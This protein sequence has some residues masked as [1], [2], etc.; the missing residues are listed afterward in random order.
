MSKSDNS[1]AIRSGHKESA[2]LLVV[3]KYLSDFRP[4]DDMIQWWKDYKKNGCSNQTLVEKCDRLIIPLEKYRKDLGNKVRTYA[5]SADSAIEMQRMYGRESNE[6]KDAEILFNQKKR[7]IVSTIDGCGRH[8]QALVTRWFLE[9]DHFKVVDMEM[10]GQG[11]DF[12]ILIADEY[13][14]RYD[15]EVWFGH[16]KRHHAARESTMIFGGSKDNP[17][18]DYGSVPVRLKNVASDQ[19]EINM[20]SAPD[21][22][23]VMK[24]LGQ[25]RD[26][27]TGFLIACRPQAI[28]PEITAT[29]FPTVLP[30]SI[31]T[32]K[33]IIVLDFD[34]GG[35]FGKRGTGYLIHHPDFDQSSRN[36]A[37]KIIQSLGFKYDQSIYT[38]KVNLAKRFGWD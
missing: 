38:Q 6:F 24:K 10:Q 13:D 14:D 34:G 15:V 18:I 17:H 32:N 16:N 4:L 9:D 23:N 1:P 31:Q 12:D 3:R 7:Q 28:P 21:L 22:P 5:Q 2:A 27:H 33:C 19:G 26:E 30:E 25:L 20:N 8:V 37:K 36:V 11:Y 35:V 29:D